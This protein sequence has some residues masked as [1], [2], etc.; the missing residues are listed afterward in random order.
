[1]TIDRPYS[2]GMNLEDALNRIESFVG[3]RYDSKVVAALFMAC[4]MV[5]RYWN[6]Q[7]KQTA[8]DKPE[9]F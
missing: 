3:T 7:T 4:A 6:C 9:K 2:K 5:R 8:P 1:M